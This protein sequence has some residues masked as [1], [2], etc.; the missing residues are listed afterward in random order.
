MSENVPEGIWNKLVC[1]RNSL[2]SKVKVRFQN[3]RLFWY[4]LLYW[5]DELFDAVARKCWYIISICCFYAW[6]TKQLKTAENVY[7]D[8]FMRIVSLW[9]NFIRH[10]V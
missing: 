6:D 1:T 3:L 8:S 4:S 2:S 9:N 7:H 5:T 10:T